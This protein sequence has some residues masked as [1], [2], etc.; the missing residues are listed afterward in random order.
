MPGPRT[1]PGGAA[2]SLPAAQEAESRKMGSGPVPLAHGFPC[3]RIKESPNDG[4]YVK[5]PENMQKAQEFVVNHRAQAVERRTPDSE[6]K[7]P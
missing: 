5:Y 6:A 4:G 2:P 3:Y 7:S 1:G